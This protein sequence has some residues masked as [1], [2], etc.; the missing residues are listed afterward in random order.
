MDDTGKSTLI[1]YYYFFIY[2][3]MKKAFYTFLMMILSVLVCSGLYLSLIYS[4]VFYKVVDRYHIIPFTDIALSKEVWWLI[5][6]IA[7][8]MGYHMA[9][10]WW[11]IIY[12]DGVYYFQKGVKKTPKTPTRRVVKRSVKAEKE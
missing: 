1:Y 8:I 12:V 4:L 7:L 9:Q 5:A 2:F 6:V 3:S 11:Q 10:K